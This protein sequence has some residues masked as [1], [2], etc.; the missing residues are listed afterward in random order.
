LEVAFLEVALAF[1]LGVALAFLGVNLA[2]LG[3]D[4][5]F[6]LGVA[7]AFLWFLGF[8]GGADALFEG[9][10][11]FLAVVLRFLATGD[12]EE[13]RADG[14]YKVGGLI[15][16]APKNARGAVEGEGEEADCAEADDAE[17]EGLV[18]R[19]FWRGMVGRGQRAEGDATRR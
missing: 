1:F 11:T 3:V 19:L 16:L 17:V 2:F 14:S 4:L 7:L 5:A 13:D 6:F 18:R 10:G 12:L 15:F 9:A 8:L